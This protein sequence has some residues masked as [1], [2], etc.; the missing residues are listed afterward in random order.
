VNTFSTKQWAIS[1]H[2]SAN[3]TSD[4]LVR[5]A[6]RSTFSILTAIIEAFIAIGHIAKAVGSDMKPFLDSIM[7]QV[8]LGLQNRG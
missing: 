8:K 1:L 7:Q 6:F 4:R 3:L 5:P 2:F